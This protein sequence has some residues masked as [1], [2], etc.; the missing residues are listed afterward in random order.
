MIHAGYDFL[1][2][3]CILKFDK[4]AKL[5]EKKEFAKKILMER[6]QV[7]TVLEKSEKVHGRLRTLKTKHLAGKKTKEAIYRE[8][9]CTFKLNVETCYFSSRLSNERLEIAN[10]IEDGD[11]VL[12]LFSGVGPFP[13]VLAKHSEAKKIT[14]VEIGRE[15]CKYALENVRLNKVYN[16]DVV[17]GDVKRLDKLISGKFDKI[18]MLRPQLKDTFLKYVWKFCKK[19]AWIYY[20]DFGDNAEKIIDKVLGE[21]KAAKKKIKIFNF[22]KAGD[23]APYKHRWRIDFRVLN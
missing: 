14:A 3:I 21:A 10:K 12:V 20:Y 7:T 8:S 22:K 13:I 23:I 11:D 9:G 16:L 18:V 17:Q 1:G 4:K 19:G 2:N 6:K 5:K 15:C